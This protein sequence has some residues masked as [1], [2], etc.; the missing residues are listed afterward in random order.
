MTPAALAGELAAGDRPLALLDV[1]EPWEWE[2]ARIDGSR[3]VPLGDLAAR[4]G[5]LDSRTPIVTICHHGLR[6]AQARDLLSAAGF[7]GVRSLSGGIDEWARVV[8]PG[9][10]RY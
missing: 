9:M 6:S 1:R 2:I 8:A 7:S 4:L 3:L 5:Q 10:A